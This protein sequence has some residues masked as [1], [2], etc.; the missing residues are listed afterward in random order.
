MNNNKGSFNWRPYLKNQDIQQH[1]YLVLNMLPYQIQLLLKVCGY[2]GLLRY[3]GFDKKSPHYFNVPDKWINLCTEP[4]IHSVGWCI[5]PKI[6]CWKDYL[7]EILPSNRTLP[8]D[9]TFRIEEYSHNSIK[10]G[11]KLEVVDKNLISVV[12]SA[13]VADVVGGRLHI[14]YSENDTEDEGFWCHERSPLIHPVGW[15]QIIG[16][17][18]KA[19]AKYARR[20]LKKTLY[21]L[22]ESDDATWDMFL[23]VFNPV[24][25]L[26]FKKKMKL[27]AIDPLNL[28]TICVATVTE[29]LRNNYLM[30]GIDGMMAADGADCFCYH[31]SSPCIFPVGFCESN[32]IYLTPPRG[33]K[34]DFKWAEYLKKTKSEAAPVDLFRHSDHGFKEGMFLEAVDLMEPRL[35]CVAYVTKVVGRLLKVHFDGWEDEY[36]QWCDCESPDLF[37]IGWCEV[38]GYRLEPPRIDGSEDKKKKAIVKKRKRRFRSKKANDDASPTTVEKHNLNDGEDL[39]GKKQEKC[40]K[41]LQG[42]VRPRGRP[43]S[44]SKR[45]QIS[46]RKKTKS[47]V[48]NCEE[49][50]CIIVVDD[51]DDPPVSEQ[52]RAKQPDIQ[53]EGMLICFNESILNYFQSK[54]QKLLRSKRKLGEESPVSEQSNF[55]NLR[56]RKK[57]VKSAPIII[58]DSS[59]S[60]NDLNHVV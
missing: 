3:E 24:S 9:F 5:E 29:V 49:T 26:K 48:F 4:H 1:L 8:S 50:E 25:K 34:G 28:S 37:P 15:A 35:I 38:L 40:K 32:N 22:F 33:Y 41:T 7:M 46:N 23:P 47:N 11:M 17:A 20:S 30:I 45:L 54:I 6:I 39:K 51:D 58:D 44:W 52:E 53:I 59:S 27:E 21:R 16:H 18:L 10:K 56:R 13:E 57:V 36:D 2:W 12:R 55:K 42:N 19:S 31:A 60:S 14:K 43:M